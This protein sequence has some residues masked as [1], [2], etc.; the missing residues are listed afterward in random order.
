MHSAKKRKAAVA[1]ASNGESEEASEPEDTGEADGDEESNEKFNEEDTQKIMAATARWE[2]L[3]SARDSGNKQQMIVACAEFE[4]FMESRPTKRGF[5]FIA[6][7]S[8]LPQ[9]LVEYVKKCNTVKNNAIGAARKKAE[10][11]ARA[12]K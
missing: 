4:T 3:C 1:A 11:A 7:Q 10:K 5:E 2:K 6:S 12:K 9:R 8:P